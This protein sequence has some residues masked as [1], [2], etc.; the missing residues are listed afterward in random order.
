[1]EQ[2][3]LHAS[4]KW[5][6]WIQASR[7]RTLPLASAC[8]MVGGAVAYK[9]IPVAETSQFWLPF[10]WILTTVLMLQVLSNWANDLGDFENGAD[11]KTREDRAVASGRISTRSMKRA[12]IVLGGLTFAAGIGAVVF[13]LW[14][15]GDLRM[16]LLMIGLGVAAIAAAYRYT[17][18]KNPYGYKGWG[19]AMVFLFF[20]WIGVLGS[21]YLLSQVWSWWWFFPA[22]WT[23]C[24]SVLVLNLNNMR[25]QASDAAS[26]KRTLVV[27]WGWSRAK[28]YH[29]VLFAVGWLSWWIF[30]LY[31]DAGSW[32]GAGW[33][34]LINLVQLAHVRRV[35]SCEEPKLL[36]GELKKVA[37]TT[38]VAAL[39]FLLAQTGLR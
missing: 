20:G 14:E 16:V 38:A 5:R 27:A 7:P 8:V 25:D 33:I 10:V 31:L 26:G 29:V 19:D 4:M 28:F 13:S 22:T 36:D 3:I 21:A 11:D 30:A 37:L 12:V 24:M 32:R 35:L 9:S 18:G 34:A 6:D 39:F 17:A 1:M 15:S 23:G 2:P